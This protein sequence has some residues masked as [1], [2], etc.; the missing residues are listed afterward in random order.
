MTV[1]KE[2]WIAAEAVSSSVGLPV[3][4]SPSGRLICNVNCAADPI[5]GK[6]AGDDAF[7]REALAYARLIAAAPDLLEALKA[8]LSAQPNFMAESIQVDAARAAIAKAVPSGAPITLAQPVKDR[9]VQQEM[10]ER[11]Y[12]VARDHLTD[13]AAVVELADDIQTLMHWAWM[14]GRRR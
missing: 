4:A 13:K 14:E 7:N 10:V 1:A 11:S 5:H 2:M 9:L 3:V 8:L 6:V 12:S